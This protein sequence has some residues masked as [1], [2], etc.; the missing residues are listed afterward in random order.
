MDFSSFTEA[1]HEQTACQINSAELLSGEKWPWRVR[2]SL[3]EAASQA[4]IPMGVAV[5]SRVPSGVKARLHVTRTLE[6]WDASRPVATSQN[7][8]SLP[9]AAVAIR[10]PSG[11][12]TRPVGI[13]GVLASRA[14]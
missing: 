6:I 3:P 1:A 5:T 4:L 2:T 12:N 10:R 7:R 8:I 13:P 14:T 9:R 11:L